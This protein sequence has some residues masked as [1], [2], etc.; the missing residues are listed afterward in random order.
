MGR[1]T[2]T[3]VAILLAVPA[4]AS[5][6]VGVGFEQDPATIATGKKT[7][8]NIMIMRMPNGPNGGE[9]KPIVGE[10]PLVTFRSRSSGKVLRARGSASDAD[11]VAHAATAF[12]DHGPW[13]T[14]IRVRG[15]VVTEGGRAEMSAFPIGTDPAEPTARVVDVME[16]PAQAPAVP[17]RSDGSSLPWL[18]IGFGGALAILAFAAMRMGIP[19]RL[20]AR[21]GGGA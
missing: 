4:L 21:L 10:R 3:V 16:P 1:I 15:R 11:G 20:R 9:P 19:A 12:P 14:T 5:A 17:A 18:L 7:T 8:I 2:L 13:T 6:K